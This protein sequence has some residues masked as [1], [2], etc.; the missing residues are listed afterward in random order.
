MSADDYHPFIPTP[1]NAK[2]AAPTARAHA[3]TRTASPRAKEL[4]GKWEA[5][6]NEPFRGITTDGKALPDLFS[7]SPEGAPTLAMIEAVNALLAQ[8]SPEQRKSLF[9][10]ASSNMWR[11]WQNTEL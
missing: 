5:M 4:F 11:H 9:F 6:F 8:M 10:P 1:P 7:L 3:Q 2:I